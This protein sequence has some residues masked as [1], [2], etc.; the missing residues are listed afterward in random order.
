MNAAM[1][2]VLSP[3]ALLSAL[4]LLRGPDHTVPTPAEDWREA[5]VDAVICTRASQDSIVHCL[6]SLVGQTLRPRRVVLVDDGGP[7]RD[8]SAQ[9]AREFA[10]ANGLDLQV[11]VR[12]WSLGKATTLKKQA[13]EFDGDVM[14]V[15]DGDTVLDA[16]DYI[17]RCVRELYQGAGIASACG[18]MLPLQRAQRD[19]VAA[20]APFRAWQAGDRYV[21]PAAGG[22]RL[23]R[24]CAWL[25]DTYRECLALYEQ[26]F[27]NRGQMHRLGGITQPLGGAVA[28]RR[29]Y[30]KDLFDRYEPIRGDDLTCA[31]DVFIGLALANEGYRNIQVFDV[32]ARHRG[33]SVHLLPWQSH[34]WATAFLQGGHFFDALLRTPFKRAN[35][36]LR[37]APEMPGAEQRVVVEAYRQPFGERCTRRYGRPIG[38]ALGLAALERIW[39]PTAVVTLLVLGHGALLAGMLALEAT[40]AVAVMAAQSPGQ[41]MRTALKGVLTTPLRYALML[42]ELYS[43]VLFLL[44]LAM[45]RTPWYA[46]RANAMSADRR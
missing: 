35:H 11:V 27:I 25:G 32:S 15:L 14:F 23:H 40:L 30:L 5:R 45:G 34:C 6:A 46:T 26:R 31:E 39:V 44:Q 24:L 37:R 12:Q 43:M 41:R 2:F 19:A 20:S 33:T 13:R 3:R 29:R 8:H 38:H 17:E 18:Q 10:S 4:G 42:T 22:D 1:W 21:D 28:Y 36:W 7:G 9:M 16:P